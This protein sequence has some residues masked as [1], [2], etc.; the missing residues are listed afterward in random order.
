MGKSQVR[1]RGVNG[2][3]GQ[4]KNKSAP[5]QAPASLRVKINQDS[6]EL[7]GLKSR[8][9]KHTRYIAKNL[10]SKTRL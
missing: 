10:E 3:E 9:Q 6:S 4:N 1:I 5:N 7:I 2:A 8:S